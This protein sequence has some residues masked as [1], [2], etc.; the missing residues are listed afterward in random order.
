[1]SC[2]PKRH[3]GKSKP[4]CRKR[5][6]EPSGEPLLFLAVIIFITMLWFC[7]CGGLLTIIFG[8]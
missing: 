8:G 3:C 5:V 1:M 4:R 6:Q 7:G 2:K